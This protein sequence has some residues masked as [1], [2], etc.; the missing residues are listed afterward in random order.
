MFYIYSFLEWF[1]AI[2]GKIKSLILFLFRTVLKIFNDFIPSLFL[3]FCLFFS[4]LYSFFHCLSINEFTVRGN[5]NK[6]I[7]K[8]SYFPKK[9]FY[10][11]YCKLYIKMLCYKNKV[12]CDEIHSCSKQLRKIKENHKKETG[13]EVILYPLHVFS[14]E[15]AIIVGQGASDNK[16]YVISDVTESDWKSKWGSKA[17]EWKW[18]NQDLELFNPFIKSKTDA[19]RGIRAIV[20]KVRNSSADFAVFPDALPEYT[21]RSGQKHSYQKSLLFGKESNLHAGPFNFPKL[22]LK[23]VLPYYI[24]IKNGRLKVEVLPVISR[25]DVKCELPLI[26]EYVIGGQH[27]TQWLLWHFP[28]FFY[29]QG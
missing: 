8:F 21:V 22:M 11:M 18:S 7:R 15:L 12:V 10:D 5:T 26:I 4:V 23:D 14:D 29:R 25:F 16:L 3:Y 6:V 1:V 13:N 28:S 17:E 24:Y 20:K 9:R 19:S 2:L 27:Y